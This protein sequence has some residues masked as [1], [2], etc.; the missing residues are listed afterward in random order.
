MKSQYP[1]N[2]LDTNFMIFIIYNTNYILLS[3]P[4]K[5][6]IK[7]SELANSYFLL[8]FKQERFYNVNVLLLIFCLLF[9]IFLRC[10][11]RN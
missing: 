5:P 2:I 6:H 9:L 7:N 10:I 3:I 11:E 8:K 1:Y 4:I